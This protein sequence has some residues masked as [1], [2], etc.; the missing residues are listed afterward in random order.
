LFV[1]AKQNTDYHI[2][3]RQLADKSAQQGELLS[4]SDFCNFEIA[5]CK[6]LV[7]EFKQILQR[8]KYQ[9]CHIYP[10]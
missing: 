6:N 2:V 10:I 4:I 8:T 3:I 7:T 1:F 9:I 5:T